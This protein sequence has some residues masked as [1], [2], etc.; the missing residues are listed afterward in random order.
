MEN[1]EYQASAFLPAVRQDYTGKNVALRAAYK[2]LL[3]AGIKWLYYVPGRELFGN[4]GEATVDGVHA[5]DLG[6]KRL[7][8]CLV[9]VISKALRINS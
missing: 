1:I 7:A 2:R 9:P 6:F 3:A 5:T 8:E 4:D